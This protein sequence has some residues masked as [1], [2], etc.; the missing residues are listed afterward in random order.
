MNVSGRISKKEKLSQKTEKS[1]PLLREKSAF[2]VSVRAYFLRFVHRD[3]AV[4]ADDGCIGE[5]MLR[6]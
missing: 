5:D 6:I 1:G 4:Q 3:A 2:I